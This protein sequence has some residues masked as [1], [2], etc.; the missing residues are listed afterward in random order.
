MGKVYYF[1]YYEVICVD[2]DIIKLCIVYDV[3]VWLGRNILSFNDCL[4]VGFLLFFFIY[5]V[6]LRFWVYKVVFI[7]DI[8]K[9]FLNVLVYL[10]DCDYFCFLWID[11][12]ISSCLKF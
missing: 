1:F 6:F 9:V 3:S 4:Y 11:D 10:R 12:I 5:D 2:K 7:G 8:E